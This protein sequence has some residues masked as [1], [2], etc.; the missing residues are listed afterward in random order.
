MLG[1]IGA[2]TCTSS[3]TRL[4]SRILRYA[5]LVVAHPDRSLKWLY[6]NEYGQPVYRSLQ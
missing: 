4:V 5:A 3:F 1:R 6:R 2:I